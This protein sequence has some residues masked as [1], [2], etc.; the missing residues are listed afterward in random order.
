MQLTI[1]IKFADT[2]DLKYKNILEISK[3]NLFFK[4]FN[5]TEHLKER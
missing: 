3:W 4:I 2:N 5:S 1:K